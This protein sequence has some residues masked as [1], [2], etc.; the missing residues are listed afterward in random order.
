M[1]AD[2]VNPTRSTCGNIR[3]H[4]EL[5]FELSN[6]F[7]QKFIKCFQDCGHF[8]IFDVTLMKRETRDREKREL[9]KFVVMSSLIETKSKAF[10]S[11][12]QRVRAHFRNE[13][14]MK[15]L[16]FEQVE[17]FQIKFWLLLLRKT[18]FEHLQVTLVKV[19]KLAFRFL[20]LKFLSII[21]HEIRINLKSD[22]VKIQ[23]CS[24]QWREII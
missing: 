4:L 11:T 20:L 8:R 24:N 23:N 17:S 19:T 13:K 1:L 14:L 12:G 21:E 2:Q 16:H 22:T 5:S 9:I 6:G 7:V 15:K 18:K 10:Q 3:F